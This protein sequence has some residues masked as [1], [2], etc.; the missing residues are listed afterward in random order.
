MVL[1]NRQQLSGFSASTGLVGSLSS[2]E[3]TCL[4]TA[5][6]STVQAV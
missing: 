4:T 6:D 2:G 1:A 3:L 5:F